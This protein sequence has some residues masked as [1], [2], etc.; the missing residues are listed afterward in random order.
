MESPKG[1]FLAKPHAFMAVI[2]EERQLKNGASFHSLTT[3]L[4]HWPF[5]REA[6]HLFTAM[7]LEQMQ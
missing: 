2:L 3:H 1:L 4:I 7:L 6:A 5:S